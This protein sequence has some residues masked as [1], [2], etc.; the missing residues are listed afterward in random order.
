V[1]KV[2]GSILAVLSLLLAGCALFSVGQ[3]E[4]RVFNQSGLTG[5]ISYGGSGGQ[6]GGG[7]IAPCRETDF[8]LVRGTSELT[9]RIGSSS[10]TQPVTTPFLGLTHDSFLIRPDGQ[11]THL[12]ETSSSSPAPAATS[13]SA[14]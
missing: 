14:G 6:G 5:A 2:A 13:C 4:V 1:T 9:I 10:L 12:D 11:I 3:M 7:A 8:F